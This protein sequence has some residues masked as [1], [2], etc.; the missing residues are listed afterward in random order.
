MKV[1][2]KILVIL[3]QIYQDILNRPVDEEG[4][5]N[6]SKYLPYREHFIRKSLLRSDEYL[7]LKGLKPKQNNNPSKI[8]YNFIKG[9][10]PKLSLINPKNKKILVLSLVNNC[11]KNKSIN[12][13]KTFIDQLQQNF[14]IVKFGALT[15]N[16][17]DK[18]IEK[19]LEW[20]K[21]NQNIYIHQH[22]NEKISVIENN[23]CG[24]RI[25]KLAEYRELIL[26]LSLDYFGTDFDYIIVFDSDI[27]F[28]AYMV[29]N[30]IIES[31]S[32]DSKWSAIS[33]NNCFN[34]SNIHYDILALRLQNHPID[35]QKIYPTFSEY[36]GKTYQWNT[37]LYIFKDYVEVQCAFGALT[38]YN[39]K[40]I[41]DLYKTNHKLY[42]V[43]SLPPCTCEHIGLDLKLKNKHYINSSM[44]LPSNTFSENSMYSK[45][46]L[47]LPRDAG[48]FSVF[49]FLIGIMSTGTK[50]Y[51]FF[52]KKLFLK[53]RKSNQHFCYW[54]ESDN[55]WFDYFKPVKYCDND[56]NH[57]NNKFLTYP[58]SCGDEGPEEFRI[59]KVFKSLLTK[60]KE[61]F[62]TWRNKIHN[63]YDQYIE[64]HPDI[65]QHSEQ[66]FNSL[67]TKSDYIIGL[68]YRH[69]S[70]SV[71][72]GPIFLQ[73]YFDEIDKILKEHQEAKI[74]LATD[75]DFGVVSF[76]HKYGEKIKYIKNINRLPIDNILEWAFA[77]S[78][79]NKTDIVGM[80]E[81]KG[82]E[83]HHKTISDN[84][85]Q[86]HY[87]FTKDL[88][89]E[90][91]CLS[92][93]N[94]LVN[95]TSN[96]SLALSYINPLIPIVTI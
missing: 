53:E 69:P 73:Q 58:L 1:N 96:I 47:F 77:L 61:L 91:L 89:T 86:S 5:K 29:V 43:S 26:K 39:A 40:E 83:L 34:K 21:E 95:S 2:S 45:E 70:H 35:I 15:N 49:N 27:I 8:E 12:T 52:N 10:S 92:K 42:D 80:I 28:D 55:C 54:T 4:I 87:S 44:K 63:V 14:G 65:M 78:K 67:F 50:A 81:G 37:S 24:N 82:Y 75:T 71:E 93:C 46:V 18:T 84:N 88:L 36:Y 16:N 22:K 59:P 9:F 48:F 25:T 13:I 85:I 19:L 30:K 6:Y 60:D 72:S 23:L 31:V 17:I 76:Q 3:N 7:I 74:F 94:I 41:I 62:Q 66:T 51:P 33:A 11:V 57:T 38:I 79:N 90:V 32:I 68:H 64:F 20:Q 56:N